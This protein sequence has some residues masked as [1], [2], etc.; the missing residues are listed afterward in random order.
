[1]SPARKLRVFI[2]ASCFAGAIA[3]HAAG[4]V[5]QVNTA[6]DGADVAPGDGICDADPTPAVQCTLRAAFT[7]AS[8]RA[9]PG[10]E[11]A[12]V[13]LQALTYK[14]TIGAGVPDDFRN[15]DLYATGKLR[16]E[17]A[18]MN[19]TV[20]DANMVDRF[21]EADA[22]SD[23]TLVDLRIVN[24]RPGSHGKGGAIRSLGKLT[25]IRCFVALNQ[26]VADD[27][28][29]IAIDGSGNASLSVTDSLVCCNVADNNAKGGGIALQFGNARLVRST[30]SQNAAGY[31]GGIAIYSGSLVAVNS[32]L[33]DN[34]GVNGGGGIALLSYA[35]GTLLNTTVVKNGVNTPG[36]GGGASLGEVA[37]LAIRSSIFSNVSG[38]T[39][40]DLACVTGPLGATVS[41]N[42]F[43]IIRQ[44]G[45]CPITGAHTDPDP[46]VSATFANNGGYTETKMLLPGSPAIDAGPEGGCLDDVG[47]ALTTDQRGVKRPIGARCDLGA[48]EAEPKGDANGDGLVNVSDVFYLINYLFAGGTPPLGRANVNG[49]GLVNVNDV[50]YLINNL[51]AGGAPPV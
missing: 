29:A 16:V 7:E 10:V 21:L 32:T 14:L 24:G 22:A 4:P 39:P 20:I 42:G 1:M 11:E 18:G 28:G 33:A 9:N 2:L 35:S 23:V 6:N 5:Y 30:I 12:V 8:F 19:A 50:F 47:A 44:P 40:D 17:G 31:G 41:T 43:A 37:S 25:L 48:V 13:K 15:G 34:L 36:L 51:F 45:A 38:T 49:D 26:T 3:A 46:L 27:G